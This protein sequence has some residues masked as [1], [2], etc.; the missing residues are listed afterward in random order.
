MF[1]CWRIFKNHKNKK[2]ILKDL[3]YYW[4]SDFRTHIEIKRWKKIF[5]EIKKKA[6]SYDNKSILNSILNPKYKKKLYNLDENKDFI[7]FENKD[8]FFRLDKERGLSLGEFGLKKE[9]KKLSFIR[10]YDQGDFRNERLN[11]DF[12]NGHNVSENSNIKVTDLDKKG[13]IKI[14]KNSNLLIFNNYFISKKKIEINK[15]WYFDL[16]TEILYLKNEIKLFETD[17]LSIRANYFNLN[18]DLN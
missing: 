11:A 14:N 1:F 13:I 17:F 15:T 9:N 3:C 6:L 18:H 16:S 4:S 5:L 12:F 8:L 7:Y 10:K 2:N